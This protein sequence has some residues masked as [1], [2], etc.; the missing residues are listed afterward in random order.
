M[1][2]TLPATAPVDMVMP[3]LAQTWMGYLNWSLVLVVL[4]FALRYWKSSGSPVGVLFLLGGALATLNEPIV[5]VL[6]KVWFP[7]VGA[8]V[9]ITAW[10]V[11]IPTYM[12]PVYAWYVGGQAFLAYRLYERGLT[13]KQ[14]FRLYAA[15]AAVNV[16]LE[17]PGLQIPMYS[18]YGNQPFVVLGFPLW[19]TFVNA[20]MP[21]TMAAL[22]FRLDPVL[23]GPRR[24]LVIPMT[25]MAAAAVNGM[26]AAPVWVALNAEGG[27]LA[28][29]HAAAVVS[30]FLGLMLCYGLSLMAKRAS[31]M[32]P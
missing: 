17:V 22:V 31:R 5:D 29:T 16:L 10:G 21:M 32:Q 15:F 12:V 25:W 2:S 1:T 4:F 19:W 18:Y 27:T 26:V 30:L 13:T 24:L 23:R 14:M 28:L 6:G 8:E 11:S 3:A 20:L 7:A 9:L